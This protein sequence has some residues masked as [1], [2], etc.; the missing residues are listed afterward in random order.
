LFGSVGSDEEGA[1]G[2]SSSDGKPGKAVLAGV[3][4]PSQAMNLAAITHIWTPSIIA[5]DQSHI[6]F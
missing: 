5:L 3:A 1:G 6:S 2:G 4:A